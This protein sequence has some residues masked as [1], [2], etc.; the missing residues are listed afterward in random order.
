M[1]I[2]SIANNP[3]NYNSYKNC[4]PRPSAQSSAQTTSYNKNCDTVSF[5]MRLSN[6]QIAKSIKS[7]P[8]LSLSK[9]GILQ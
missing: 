6:E 1:K 3:C 5:G 8:I 2:Y 7:L 4:C 9:N